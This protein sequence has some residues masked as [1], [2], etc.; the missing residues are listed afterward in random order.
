MQ[1]LMRALVLPF[2]TTVLVACSNTPAADGAA[3]GSSSGGAAD[4]GAGGSSSGGSSAAGGS[5]SDGGSASGG[6]AGGGSAGGFFG[7]SRCELGQFALCDGFEASTIDSERW[8]IGKSEGNTV[9]R[10]SDQAARGSGSVHVRTQNGFG[11]LSTSSIFPAAGNGYFGRVFLRVARYSTVDWAHWTVAEAAGTGDGS[12]IR[13]GGQFVTS[14][15]KNRWGVGSD[16]G[17]T[18]DWTNH[19]TDP[20]GAPLEPPLGS[21]TC[22]EWQ[23]DG[24]TN[25]TRFYVD[26][27]EHPSLLT[28]ASEHGGTN[29]PYEL[30]QMNSLWVG[31]WQYQADPTAFDVWIDEVA[32]DDERIGCE[33]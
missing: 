32:L 11:Y 18:G 16:G 1:L 23:H 24:A 20:G 13:V 31:W 8:T 3:G 15:A 25:T 30:P 10:V 28:T 26:S 9:E 12:K 33:R 14:Q 5:T 6:S 29:V 27:I 4:G 7:A 21:W 22:L 17:P 19:D 2:A